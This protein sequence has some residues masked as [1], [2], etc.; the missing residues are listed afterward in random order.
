[1]FGD[2]FGLSSNP[3]VAALLTQPGVPLTPPV[4][5]PPVPYVSART[6]YMDPISGDDANDGLTAS[7]PVQRWGRAFAV[8]S[9]LLPTF[10]QMVTL[11]VGNGQ[12]PAEPVPVDIPNNVNIVGRGDN[13]SISSNGLRFNQVTSDAGYISISGIYCNNLDIDITG[14]PSTLVEV[15]DCQLIQASFLSP[16]NGNEQIA[17]WDCFS[18]ETTFQG[19]VFADGLF[20]GAVIVNS[21]SQVSYT[22]G[23][24]ASLDL[25]GNSTTTMQGVNTF[26][27]TGGMTIT[28][29]IIG[30]N[31]P[32][33]NSDTASKHNATIAGSVNVVTL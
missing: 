2:T 23:Q 5:P 26:G 15:R 12:P 31:T 27:I 21:G 29:H 17:V 24:M 16:N 4:P 14:A 11:F 30:G 1:M 22:G 32:T 6:V 18:F 19:S 10:Q 33:L 28:G 25:S 8:V 20:G 9:S 3:S 13:T 7:T